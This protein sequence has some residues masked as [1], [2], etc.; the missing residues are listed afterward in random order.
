MTVAGYGFEV[1]PELR[2]NLE[3]FLL[4]HMIPKTKR[5]YAFGPFQLD[6]TEC[7]LTLDGR[8]VPLAPKAFEALV[9][10]VENAGHLIDKDDLMKRL[11]PDSFVEEGNVAKHVSLL[12]KVLSEATNGQE[13]IET[14]PKR[15]YRFAA[16]VRQLPDAQ[17]E[18]ESQRPDAKPRHSF[19]RWRELA[20]GVLAVLLI[21]SFLWFA[22]RRPSAP[23]V[24]PDLRLRQLTTNSAEN[25]VISG[26]ISPDGNYLAYSDLAGVHIQNI[27]SGER[28]SVPL[29]ETL[30]GDKAE[31]EV[32]FW[33]PDSTRFFSNAH[34]PGQGLWNWDSENTSIW[35]ISVLGGAPRKLRD[36]ASSSTISP[37]GS[38][39]SF[40]TSKGRF[41]D[42]EIWLMN[43]NG[44][45]ARR[46]FGPDQESSISE[47]NWSQNSKRVIYQVS[48]S[49]GNRILS[50]DLEGGPPTTVLSPS[51]AAGL[52]D[53]VWLP[54]GPLMYTSGEAE[55]YGGNNT[56]NF[57]EIQLDGNTGKPKEKPKRLTNWPGLCS[58]GLSATAD[59]K[60]LAFVRGSVHFT[61]YVADLEPTGTR[62]TNTKHFTLNDSV[63]A[64]GDWTADSSAIILVSDRTG[65]YGIYEQ[66]L[67]EDTAK[68]IVSGQKELRNARLT[69]DGNWVL[70]HRDI[71]P[72]NPSSETEVLRVPITGGPTEVIARTRADGFVMCARAPSNLCALAEPTVDRKQIVITTFDPVKGRGSEITRFAFEVTGGAWQNVSLSPDGTRL[73]FIHSPEG[74]IHILPLRG[75]S[76]KEIALKGWSNLQ[77]VDWNA[78]GTGLFV[79]NG[80]QRGVVL[81]HVDLQG[82][83]QVFW[84][85]HGFNTTTA[86]PSPDGRHLAILGSTNDNNI[87]MMENF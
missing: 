30:N 75:Q 36:H 22:K 2:R 25:S 8:P 46:L 60:R 41:G 45:H 55:A 59:G 43:Q 71:N 72:E 63:D 6:P 50:R 78:D 58:A 14:I 44:E 70:F 42:R 28:Q 37:D 54:D 24:V 53:Y 77:S 13:Y 32:G 84:K 11:W 7:L 31:W 56:C 86:R 85:N 18:S 47:L 62:I 39:V 52:R 27:E 82:N 34:R 15:G 76:S 67:N 51:E 57:W 21:A 69:P 10:L 49:S 9:I 23:E 40:G 87:W 81:L 80:I 83:A 1:L 38:S 33:S 5:F 65:S 73:A 74:P 26:T 66:G 61:T 48:D 4:E 20:A 79:S 17:A 64:P 16:D 68:P 3:E 19:V 12:R 29:P 35:V